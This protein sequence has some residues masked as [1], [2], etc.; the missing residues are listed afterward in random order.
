MGDTVTDEPTKTFPG[1]EWRDAVTDAREVEIH[2]REAQYHLG[3]ATTGSA[4]AARLRAEMQELRDEYARLFEEAR[5][6]GRELA[7]TQLSSPQS[8]PRGPRDA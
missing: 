1:N 7:G 5:R 2:W 4:E 3:D 6:H 8:D